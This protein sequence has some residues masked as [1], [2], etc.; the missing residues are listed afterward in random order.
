MCI[1]VSIFMETLQ[2]VGQHRR[3]PSAYASEHSRL[4]SIS[5]S[6]PR[7]TCRRYGISSRRTQ[8]SVSGQNTTTAP[9]FPHQSPPR[10]SKSQFQEWDRIKGGKCFWRFCF[11]VPLLL[12]SA[13]SWPPYCSRYWWG[14]A[15]RRELRRQKSISNATNDER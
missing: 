4:H 9:I 5:G 6:Q 1:N 2:P 8:S 10:G 14:R 7:H 12:F 3:C 15:E 11:V 13:A